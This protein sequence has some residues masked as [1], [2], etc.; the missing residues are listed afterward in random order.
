MSNSCSDIFDNIDKYLEFDI[1]LDA[2]E[3]TYEDI[4]KCYN[5]NDD[6][7]I[8][9]IFRSISIDNDD[10]AIDLLNK[11]ISIIKTKTN[12]TTT[13]NTKYNEV[14]KEIFNKTDTNNNNWLQI[15]CSRLDHKYINSSSR[16][17]NIKSTIVI[18][19][20]EIKKYIPLTNIDNI[21]TSG[22]NA[23]LIACTNIYL[24]NISL[25][26]LANKDNI[27]YINKSGDTVLL[28]CSYNHINLELLDK[29]LD[30]YSNIDVNIGN[31]TNVL[32][33]LITYKKEE[34]N[35]YN[36]GEN[37]NTYREEGEED[38]S[39]DSRLISIV[40]KLIEKG[41]NLKYTTSSGLNALVLCILDNK[42]DIFKLI[43]DKLIS[44]DKPYIVNS[45]KSF[46]NNNASAA[47]VS[48]NI[49]K[50]YNSHIL[51]KDKYSPTSNE[52]PLMTP[53]TDKI[54]STDITI[55]YG[56]E[57]EICIKLDKK[58]IKRD[59]D[60]ES[61]IYSHFTSDSDPNIN[62]ESPKEWYDLTAIFLNEYITKRVKTNNKFKLLVRKSKELYKFII[63]TNAPKNKDYTYVYDLDKLKLIK[64]P[65]TIDYTKPI[66]TTD[67]SVICGD[68]KYLYD[69][70]LLNINKLKKEYNIEH[71]FHI[72]FVTPIL[73]CN[74]TI[75]KYGISYDLSPLNDLF[76]LIGMDKTGCY[77]TNVSQ[78]FHVNLSLFNN[79]TRKPLPLLREFFKTQFIK[80]YVEWEKEAYPKYRKG[81][82]KFAKP[83]YSLITP[84][85]PN[86]G[87]S[88]IA[89]NKYVSLHRKDLQE[90]IEIRLFA[91]TNDYK[92]LLIRTK[93]ALALL[94]SSYNKWYSTVKPSIYPPVIKTSKNNTR[95]RNNY[96]NLS[97]KPNKNNTR[98]KNR[99][100]A[101]ERM[102][103][104]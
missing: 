84:D 21:N 29:L 2:L 1:K 42:V 45:I 87:Y 20:P 46:I 64:Q 89:S 6:N 23:L 11:I 79:K 97:G 13:N 40:N 100:K 102:T 52:I 41:I 39:D 28:K 72:E 60:T 101:R 66:I 74:P 56:V 53:S 90:L 49:I 63:V 18:L 26:Y 7:I 24:N 78:G 85:K 4:L 93:E 61:I 16:P 82:S 75:G 104:K 59:I 51:L 103:P 98:S 44:T 50:Y 83:L 65:G 55:K 91:A 86:Y 25:K 48:P 69:E 9:Y 47:S 57:L 36:E 17:R 38:N 34:E 10:L 99:E 31:N 22:E 70:G 43:F 88:E 73:D 80:N 14:L 95:K 30:K 77:V 54:P 71:T 19:T 68:Y 33:N 76:M 12:P 58:C 5:Y 15:L 8:M 32:F 67:S 3:I 94:Y 37:L 81:V 92:N 35:I 62:T 27:N 96:I